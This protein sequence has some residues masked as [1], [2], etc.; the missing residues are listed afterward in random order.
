MQFINTIIV[1]IIIIINFFGNKL[2]QTH[3]V[4][5]DIPLLQF[6]FN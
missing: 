1:S 6:H 4:F 2:M 5:N 3:E